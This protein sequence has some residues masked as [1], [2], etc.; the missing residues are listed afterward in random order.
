MSDIRRYAI[1]LFVSIAAVV[2]AI[3]TCPSQWPGARKLKS[4][5]SP[6]V[7]FLGLWQGEW[8]LFA[9]N[10][11]INNAWLTAEFYDSPN[12]ESGQFQP[13]FKTW[14]SPLWVKASPWEKFYGFRHVNYFNRLPHT[15]MQKVEDFGDYITRNQLGTH[16]RPVVTSVD[17][18]EMPIEPSD[19]VRPN[20]VVLKLFYNRLNIAMP[21]DGTLAG[22]EETVWVSVGESLL[23]RQYRP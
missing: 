11:V 17:S 18:S 10:P 15:H 21:D 16:Y 3:E 8:P 12:L 13:P 9:P 23:V 20:T 5:V 4:W 2:I 6:S 7:N 22:P 1:R 19:D 14:N